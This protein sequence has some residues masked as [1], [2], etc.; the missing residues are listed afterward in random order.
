MRRID[1]SVLFNNP[2]ARIDAENRERDARAAVALRHRPELIQI[3]RDNLLRWM[4]ADGKEPH[5]AHLEW[6][7]ILDFLTAE[8]VAAFLESRTPKAERLRQSSPFVG[9][10]APDEPAFATA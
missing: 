1:C 8:E 7:A 4:S 3:A 2:H 5:A 9:L 6:E 10:P